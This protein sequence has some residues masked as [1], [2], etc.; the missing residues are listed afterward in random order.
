MKSLKTK[1]S[2]RR[3]PIH[4]EIIKIGFLEYVNE[5]QKIA[6]KGFLFPDLNPN[7][8]SG[9]RAKTFSQWFGRLRDKFV[10]KADPGFTKDFHGFRHMVT[11]QIRENAD[12]DE[13]RYA[14]L[15]WTD[16]SQKKNS[17]YNYGTGFPI[18]KLHDL[19]EKIEPRVDLSH[20]Y[21]CKT[22]AV[23]KRARRK[24]G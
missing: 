17:G 16:G 14:L 22:K 11:D 10:K 1:V 20:L 12:S 6:S 5:R 3:V 21:L 7:K 24:K 23:R 2:R 18:K 4:S 19:V 15:G 9:N 8:K 13:L